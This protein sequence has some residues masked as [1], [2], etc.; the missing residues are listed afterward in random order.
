MG[1]QMGEQTTGQ[2]RADAERPP[3]QAVIGDLR[4]KLAEDNNRVAGFIAGVLEQVE[5]SFPGRGAVNI[6]LLRQ[7]ALDAADTISLV[8]AE[9]SETRQ[10]REA[11]AAHATQL[12]AEPE[13]QAGEATPEVPQ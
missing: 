12:A 1:E 4:A 11:R 5:R 13:P 9:W 7:E 6:E 8:V 2:P 10:L 3:L